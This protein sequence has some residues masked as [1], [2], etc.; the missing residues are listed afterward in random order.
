MR[1]DIISAAWGQILTWIFFVQGFATSGGL[2]EKLRD[3]AERAVLQADNSDRRARV[4][5]SRQDRD[6]RA[7]GTS[8]GSAT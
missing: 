6:L 4:A 5:A 2:D 8:A 1:A 7:V 3:G